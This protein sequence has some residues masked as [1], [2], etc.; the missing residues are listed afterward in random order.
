MYNLTIIYDNTSETLHLHMIL[1][2]C[3]DI[4]CIFRDLHYF[5]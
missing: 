4:S 1:C 5:V 2:V 3:L